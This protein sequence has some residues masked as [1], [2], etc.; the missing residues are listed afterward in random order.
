MDVKEIEKVLWNLS[1]EFLKN[2]N[3][4]LDEFTYEDLISELHMS[5]KRRHI[6]GNLQIFEVSTNGNYT[7]AIFQFS[8]NY[9]NREVEMLYFGMGEIKWKLM[10]PVA[11]SSSEVKNPE[12]N[13][14]DS[15]EEI[16]EKIMRSKVQII[17][18]DPEINF[19]TASFIDSI[20]Y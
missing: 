8:P 14:L 15:Q 1:V 19:S 2:N 12:A 16:I 10:L 18:F 7:E 11:D 6:I 17:N 13:K 9:L 3:T 20:K 4:M 5:S